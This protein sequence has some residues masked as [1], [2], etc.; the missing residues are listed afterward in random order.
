MAY[1][2]GERRGTKECSASTLS[3]PVGLSGSTVKRTVLEG[4]IRVVATI[5]RVAYA[6]SQAGNSGVA[7]ANS[8]VVI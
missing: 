4:E 5:Y 6:Q 7:L 2:D 8:D 1:G 3:I